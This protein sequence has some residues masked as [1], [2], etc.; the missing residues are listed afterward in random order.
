MAQRTA[1]RSNVS[2]Y[3]SLSLVSVRTSESAGHDQTGM[4]TLN[5]FW[6]GFSHPHPPLLALLQSRGCPQELCP[7]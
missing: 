3:V 6:F 7:R 5:G 1:A 4:L 2:L